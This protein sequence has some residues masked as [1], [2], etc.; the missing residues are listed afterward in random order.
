MVKVTDGVTTG[1][2][3]SLRAPSIW[4]LE[5]AAIVYYKGG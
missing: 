3:E 4:L 2:L 5:F 1:R